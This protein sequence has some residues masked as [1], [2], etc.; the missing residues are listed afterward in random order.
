LPKLARQFDYETISDVILTI[1]YTAREGGEQTRNAVGDL[2]EALDAISRPGDTL[3]GTGQMHLFSARAEFPEA[4]RNFVA[5]GASPEGAMISLDLSEQRFP[6]PPKALGTRTIEYVAVFFRWSANAALGP[7]ND[8]FLDAE[9]MA[10]EDTVPLGT[11][12]K[13]EPDPPDSDAGYDY[14]AASTGTAINK[15]P[16]TWSLALPN[17]WTAGRDPEDLIIVVGHKVS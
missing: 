5:S 15:S 16:G 14:Y 11:F 12:S 10:G 1:R 13:Y 3:H 8:T 6:H 2:V 7:E 4:W 17:G 9:L